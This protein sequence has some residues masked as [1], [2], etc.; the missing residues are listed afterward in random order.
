[1]PAH[2][3]EEGRAAALRALRDE[4]RK[5]VASGRGKPADEVLDRLERKYT[6]QA[7]SRRSK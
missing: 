2:R 1:M 5:G 3:I 6:A 7:L 4:V